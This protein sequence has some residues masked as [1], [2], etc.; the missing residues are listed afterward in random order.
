HITKLASAASHI[1][2]FVAWT[3]VA[4][5]AVEGTRVARSSR[6]HRFSSSPEIQPSDRPTNPELNSS[7]NLHLNHLWGSNIGEIDRRG[8]STTIH[9]KHPRESIACIITLSAGALHSPP[10][11]TQSTEPKIKR[12]KKNKREKLNPKRLGP[13]TQGC[14]SLHPPETKADDG[15]TEDASPPRRQKTGGDGSL[16]RNRVVTLGPEPRRLVADQNSDRRN[17]EETKRR[18]K[19]VYFI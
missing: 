13:V 15:G 16:F 4:I 10:T 2:L 19:P 12:K 3:R 18:Q 7:V 14:V 5:L 8:S 6:H 11:S 9:R 17:P 1:G